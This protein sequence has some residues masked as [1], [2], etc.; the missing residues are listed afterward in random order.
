MDRSLDEILEERQVRQDQ[1]YHSSSILTCNRAP[2]VDAAEDVAVPIAMV[3]V[4]QDETSPNASATIPETVSKRSAYLKTDKLSGYML[5]LDPRRFSF[6]PRASVNR[7]TS[8][9]MR[10]QPPTR[11]SIR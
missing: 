2:V 4:V 1:H 5:T 10:R 9:N 6:L 7:T 3:A 11:D 8:I